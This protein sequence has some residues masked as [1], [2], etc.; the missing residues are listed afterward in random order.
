MKKMPIALLLVQLL[1]CAAVAPQPPGATLDAAQRAEA[2][3]TVQQR[4]R[5]HYVDPQLRG[6]DWDA[7][8]ARLRP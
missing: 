1:G 8:A 4:V 2:F 5:E 3:D 6:V 7:S